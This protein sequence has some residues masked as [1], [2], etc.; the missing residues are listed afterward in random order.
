MTGERVTWA[1][2]PYIVTLKASDKRDG[3]VRVGNLEAENNT[4]TRREA[5]RAQQIVQLI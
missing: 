5:V 4:K 3:V 1:D 2:S